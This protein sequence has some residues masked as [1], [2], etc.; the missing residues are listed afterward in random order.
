MKYTMAVILNW[1]QFG[2]LGDTWQCLELGSAPGVLRLEARVAA[3][4]SSMDRRAPHD[5]EL[6]APNVRST[7]AEKPSVM[8]T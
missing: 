6:S 7:K 8:V 2:P 4:H 1:S 3:Q 5:K